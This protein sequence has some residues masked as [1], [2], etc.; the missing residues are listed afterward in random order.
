[1]KKILIICLLWLWSVYVYAGGGMTHMFLAQEAIKQ[2]PD[3]ELRHLLQDNIDAY[4]VGA[5]YPDSGYIAEN[6]YGEDS[7]WDPFIQAFANY[8][9]ETYQDPAVQHPKL[10]AF[11]FGCAAHRVSDD[12]LHHI[13]FNVMKD[14]DFQGDYNKAHQ[15]GD[16]GIDLLINIEKNQWLTHPRTWW[17]PINDLLAVYQRMGLTKYTKEEIIWGNTVIY[18]AGY[19]ERLISPITYFYLRW[20]MP[21]TAQHYENWAE[22]G[23]I[24][25]E[26]KVA[27]YQ[28][29]L[30]R[31]LKGKGEIPDGITKRYTESA[32]NTTGIQFAREALKR[33]TVNIRTLSKEDGS[34]ELGIIQNPSEQVQQIAEKV[35]RKVIIQ[36][37]LPQK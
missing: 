24:A 8:I 30:W 36:N 33:H 9:K 7:H 23:L 1:M 19:G 4:L 34:I 14:K 31:Y 6:S 18:L 26:Q 20:R 12:I 15:Y 21:W 13:F 2:L 17:V 37:K 10:L 11:L 35:G 5:Y 3:A 27:D 16:M 22:S 25:N 28:M 32:A 29:R